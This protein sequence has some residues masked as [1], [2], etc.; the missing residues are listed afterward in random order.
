MSKTPK[1]EGV[2]LKHQRLVELTKL[3]DAARPFYEWV[4]HQ[5]QQ[6]LGKAIDLN[7]ALM[8]MSEAEIKNLIQGC[9]AATTP[10]PPALFDG[11]GRQYPHNKAV[12]FFLA[13]MVRDA[14]AQRLKP[15]LDKVRRARKGATSQEVESAALAALFVAYRPNLGN[16]S[17]PAVR[18]VVI[19]RL[20]GSRRSIQG[21]KKELVARTAVTLALQTYY[22][23]HKNYG[24]F[25]HI[26]VSDSEVR[27]ENHTFDVGVS[28]INADGESEERVLIPVKSRETEGGGHAHLFTRDIESAIRVARKNAT[29]W[30]AP[31]IVAE[32]WSERE[33]ETVDEIS[34]FSIYVP[35]S[36]TTFETISD[37][38]QVRLNKFI[39][40]VLGGRIRP[41]ATSPR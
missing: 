37:A 25:A 19:D 24:R 16:F 30:I 29:N 27:I 7:A 28:L 5:C 31:I 33:Q 38:D 35:E 8:S 36:P 2:D 22:E 4:E 23:A 14:P 1:L 11:G 17:W 26:E 20:E 21:H 41:K 34:D 18:E 39:A 9:Y 6:M 15:L 3:A 12:Y 13:W 10:T 32:N 40:G